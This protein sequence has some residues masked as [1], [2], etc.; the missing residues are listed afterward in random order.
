MAGHSWHRCQLQ[1][2]RT[3]LLRDAKI[4]KGWSARKSQ[5]RSGTGFPPSR[6]GPVLGLLGLCQYRSRFSISRVR[7]SDVLISVRNI[8]AAGLRPTK[9]SSSQPC[10]WPRHTRYLERLEVGILPPECLNRN[11]R[12]QLYLCAKPYACCLA[13]QVQIDIAALGSHRGSFG[14]FADL[15]GLFLASNL[16]RR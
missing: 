14:S 10:A 1:R 6:A 13:R 9:V 15:F 4:R 11:F 5:S 3:Q 8:K 2:P 7:L 16:P 12:F